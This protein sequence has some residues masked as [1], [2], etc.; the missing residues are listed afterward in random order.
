[1]QMFARYAKVLQEL[2]KKQNHLPNVASEQLF[3]ALNTLETCDE[4]I[5][6]H[7]QFVRSSV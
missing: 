2:R 5:D 3:N 7:G 6:L 1:M 4:Y